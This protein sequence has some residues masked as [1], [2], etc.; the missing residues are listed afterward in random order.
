MRR[1]IFT[2]IMLA[3]AVA[4]NKE[5]QLL[6]SLK[7]D[8]PVFTTSFEEYDVENK[9]KTYVD[10]DVKL[11]WHRADELSIFRTT[12]NEK[13]TFDGNTGDNSG[14]FSAAGN[15]GQFGTGNAIEAYY[16]IY[17]Y[18]SNSSMDNYDVLTVELPATQLYAQNSFGKGANTMVAVTSGLSDYFLSFKNVGGYLVLKLYGSGITVKSIELKGNNGE[19]IAGDATITAKHGQMPNSYMNS[20]ATGTITLDCGESGVEIGNSA[21]NATSFWFV[22]P[23]VVFSEGFTVTI[24]EIS[25]LTITQST[26]KWFSVER[27]IVKSMA[28][29]EVKL[30][31]QDLL[32]REK[33]SL[34]AL[35]N[36]LGGD[37]W[38][39]NTNWC[40]DQPVGDWYGVDTDEEGFVTAIQL[41]CNNLNGTLPAEIGNFSRLTRLDMN[42]WDQPTK[43]TGT[44]PSSICNLKSLQYM[45][46]SSNDITGS[47]PANIGKLT[48]LTHIILNNCRLSGRMPESLYNLTKLQTLNLCSNYNLYGGLSKSISNLQALK[49]LNICGNPR[50]GTNTTLPLPEEICS[51]VNLEELNI[52]C[53]NFFGTIPENIGNLAKLWKLEFGGNRFT[54][55][56]P[57]SVGNLKELFHLSFGSNNLTGEIP[58]SFGNLSKLQLLYLDNNNGLEGEIP[59]E[60]FTGCTNLTELI[61]HH[62]SLTGELSDKISN[63]TKLVKLELLN[64]ELY[65]EIPE[66]ICEMTSL[67]H[68]QIQDNPFTGSIPANI[69]NLTNLENLNLGGC[70]LSGSIPESIGNL[71]NV[72]YLAIGC[73][74]L[75]GQIPESI[76]NLQKVEWLFL[77]CN[78]LSGTL[79][80]ISKMASLKGIWLDNNPN[81]EGTI[82][83]STYNKLETC[84][85]KDTKINI[86]SDPVQE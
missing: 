45:D 57:E 27:N 16:A 55:T 41:P 32:A 82:Y 53:C 33:S 30:T 56:I 85:F 59:E 86:L 63:L 72:Q 58:A 69:G 12:L 46:L 75:S 18:S 60:I 44:I 22:V 24:T 14:T 8:A 37:N 6:Q 3:T 51:L 38:S 49:V 64:N 31:T 43:I 17:P 67:T 61:L 1:I 83:L 4:C 47:I 29:L 66:S 48:E 77:N 7:N 15:G 81:L 9:T 62:C 36:S 80:D 19:K 35:Y 52:N 74:Q 5:E 40:T 20:N 68:L 42:M 39:N 54:G 65:G 34:I 76:T 50:F 10:A 73:Q 25:G 70:Q 2:I 11:Y 78:S 79:P 13:Y 28:A 71:E 26:S 84:T 21:E 23:P